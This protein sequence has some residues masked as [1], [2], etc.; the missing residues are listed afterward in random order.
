MASEHQQQWNSK[1]LHNHKLLVI[2]PETEEGDMH[3]CDECFG[4]TKQMGFCSIDDYTVCKRCYYKSAGKKM[5]EAEEKDEQTNGDMKEIE[6]KHHQLKDM[7]AMLDGTQTVPGPLGLEW[8]KTMPAGMCSGGEEEKKEMMRKAGLRDTI[9][10]GFQLGDW[11]GLFKTLNLSNMKAKKGLCSN[12]QCENA[13]KNRCAK[14]NVVSYCGRDCQKVDWKARHKR[15][16]RPLEAGDAVEICA[17]NGVKP[18]L[19]GAIGHLEQFFDD[20]GKWGL[21]TTD[22]LTVKIFWKNLIRA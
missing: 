16:C 10:S 22:D 14:C 17:G 7:K 8:L 11:S 6:Q 21:R 2:P 15:E 1:K 13:G 20:E 18:E 5:T 4:Y 3:C 9:L 19:V 12:E